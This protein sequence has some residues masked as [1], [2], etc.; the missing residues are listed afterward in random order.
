MVS[1]INE[2]LCLLLRAVGRPENLGEEQYFGG[3]NLNPPPVDIG[4]THLS[5]SGVGDRPLAPLIP[6]AQ[7]LYAISCCPSMYLVYS[8]QR[9]AFQ[10]LQILHH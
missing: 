7:L 3:H 2:S 6:T 8:Y 10:L 1:L 9:I 4:L 5:K